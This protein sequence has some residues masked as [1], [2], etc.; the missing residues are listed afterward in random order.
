MTAKTIARDD[1]LISAEDLLAA[2]EAGRRTVLL[3]I[4]HAPGGPS[5]RADYEDGH[6]PGA[7]WVELG[8]QLSGPRTPGSGNN[9]LPDPA[10]LQEDVRRWG[11][12]EDSLVVVYGE[13]G[14]PSAARGWFVLAWA[15][16][17]DVRFLDGGIDAWTAA[18][19]ALVSEEPGERA[20]TFVIAPGAL[21]TLDADEAASLAR[22]GVLL[23]ARGAKQ[24]QGEP[25]SEGQPAQGHIPGALS[26]P[27]NANLDERG[28]LR[29]EG[30]LRARFEGLGV[31]G[32]REVGVYCGGGVAA[33]HQA[34]V[35]RTL[36][37][38]AP[39]FI[40]S[41][42]AWSSDPSRAVAVGSEAG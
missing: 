4:R 40:G 25:A 7:H 38:Q 24:Y 16:V 27:T 9:P 33:A 30:E 32:T 20:G 39:V 35:L 19:G 42:S 10:V 12:D 6:L 17:P 23:D 15:G 36:G 21:P 14:A 37:I 5:K 22:R 34:L 18:G 1:L 26:A 8:S 3:D 13:T 41:W 29:P 28:R 31:D 11:I 2:I